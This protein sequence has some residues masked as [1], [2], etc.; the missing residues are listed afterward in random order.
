MKILKNNKYR[1]CLQAAIW[2]RKIFLGLLNKTENPW[3]FE[4]EA[5]V[6][7]NS[8]PNPFICVIEDKDKDYVHGPIT[9]FCTAI[10]KG[11]WMRDAIELCRNENIEVDITQR[12]VETKLQEIIRKSY[13]PLPRSIKRGYEF[14]SKRLKKGKSEI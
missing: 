8:L 1:V 13:A 5:S 10:T 9:Y 12:P 14:L 6:R 3:Q 2:K 11:I 7:S 4:T